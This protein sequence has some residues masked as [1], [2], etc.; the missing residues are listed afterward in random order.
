[1][2]HSNIAKNHKLA[3]WCRWLPWFCCIHS[4]TSGRQETT[5]LAQNH[6]DKASELPQQLPLLDYSILQEISKSTAVLD[7][8]MCL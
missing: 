4:I 8:C 6:N 2:E 5:S 7:P 3:R 1:M